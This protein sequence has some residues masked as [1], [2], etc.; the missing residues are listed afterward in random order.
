M[1]ETLRFICNSASALEARK[2]GQIRGKMP[3]SLDEQTIAI[4]ERVKQQND[5]IMSIV[6][7]K[8]LSFNT[9]PII[10]SS[11]LDGEL[12]NFKLF[13]C[14]FGCNSPNLLSATNEIG[15]TFALD[16]DLK[17]ENKVIVIVKS[18]RDLNSPDTFMAAMFSLT[19]NKVHSID[20]ATGDQSV[21][22]GVLHGGAE[23]LDESWK[24]TAGAE[25]PTDLLT[26]VHEVI[27]AKWPVDVAQQDHA[28]DGIANTIIKKIE[29]SGG[30]DIQIAEEVEQERLN[31]LESFKELEKELSKVITIE[32]S[33]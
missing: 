12:T 33:Q 11:E 3:P 8:E 16:V 32:P 14:Y 10:S 30:V 6:R 21:M 13:M 7:E 19:S 18:L 31:A 25:Q 23:L 22:E 4:A 15:R 5:I 1:F 26:M 28:V 24:I 29:E 2:Y 17:S 20:L 27:H 9:I